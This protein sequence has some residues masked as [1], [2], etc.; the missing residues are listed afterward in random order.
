M[1]LLDAEGA[2]KVVFCISVAFVGVLMFFVIADIHHRFHLM[3]PQ[4]QWNLAPEFKSEAEHAGPG[5][6]GFTG[7]QIKHAE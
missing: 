5:A 4:P 1:H 6:Q 7:T 3:N 2:N